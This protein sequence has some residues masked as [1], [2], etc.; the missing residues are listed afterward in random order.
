MWG[1]ATYTY[2]ALDNIRISVVGARNSVHN[3]NTSTNRL[4]TINTNGVLTGY[5]YDNQGNITGRG[6][7]GFYFDQGNRMRLANGKATYTYDGLGRRIVTSATD[8]TYRL[9]MYSQAGQLLFSQQQQGMLVSNT[10]YVYLGGKEIA[11]TNSATGT[12]YAHT[13]ALGSPVARTNS[14]AGLLTR[15]RYEPYGNTAAGTIPN[16]IGFAGH[17]NDPDTGLL[18][19]GS[20]VRSP[21]SPSTSQLSWCA[22]HATS[23]PCPRARRTR[24]T[25]WA[26]Q[27]ASSVHAA[28][29]TPA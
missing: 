14:S 10:R 20:R 28:P 13:D 2:D 5:A 21:I 15:T 6:T 4:D 23:S 18:Y 8:G 24:S 22:W 1:A 25:G 11:E 16:G 29:R 17:V 9:Q 19:R 3:Y 7:Q 26:D 27:A 12:S